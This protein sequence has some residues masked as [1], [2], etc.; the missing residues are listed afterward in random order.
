MIFPVFQY[1]LPLLRLPPALLLLPQ[2]VMV[3]E[4]GGLVVVDPRDLILELARLFPLFV[5]F[6]LVRLQLLKERP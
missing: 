1:L 4:K 3:V 5:S 6:G 2:L